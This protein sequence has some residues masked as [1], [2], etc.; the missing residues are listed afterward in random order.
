MSGAPTTIPA[1]TP[2][3]V[4]AAES[5]QWKALAS[6]IVQNLRVSIPGIIQSF[7]PAAQ[8]A[9]VQIALYERVKTA[10]GPQIMA[11]PAIQDVPIQMPRGGGFSVTL[12]LK[13]GDECLL[14]FCDMCI[15]LWWARGGVQP[16]FEIRRHDLSDCICIPGPWNQQRLIQNYSTNSLQVR[17]DDGTVIVDVA[18]AGITLTAPKVQINT[19]GDIDFMASGNVNISGTKVSV[20]SSDSQSTIDGKIFLLHEHTTVKTG[21]DDSGPV[22]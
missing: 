6:Q 14:V 17:S 8:T 5:A 22:A 2:T 18:E 16:Q 11:I 12:P 13:S 19:S 3:Q 21:T 20:T 15:D 4:T 10:T 9:V 7:D 1:M